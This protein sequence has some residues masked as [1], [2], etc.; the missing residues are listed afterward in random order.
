MARSAAQIEIARH[1][2]ETVARMAAQ[3]LGTPE[4]AARLGITK[5]Q[6]S[7]LLRKIRAEED[8]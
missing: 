6:C 7:I 3:G 8:Q 4:M 5:N 1:R 2:K